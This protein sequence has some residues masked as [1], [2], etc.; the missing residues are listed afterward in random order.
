MGSY[1]PST[2][3]NAQENEQ[4]PQN[5]FLTFDITG[6]NYMN[7]EAQKQTAV[8]ANQD[9]ETELVFYELDSLDRFFSFGFGLPN[10]EDSV[11]LLG[12]LRFV[13]DESTPFEQEVFHLEFVL[14]EDRINLQAKA[15]GS[16]RYNNLEVLAKHLKNLNWAGGDLFGGSQISQFLLSFPSASFKEHQINN[17]TLTSNGF[18]FEHEIL[19]F[20]NIAYHQETN[21]IDL[22]GAFTLEMKELSCGFYSFFLVENGNFHALI[23]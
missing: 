17:Q 15:N 22:S 9:I 21:Q 4:A 12:Q 19:D 1:G 2:I 20:T 13:L 14:V 3:L 5:Y 10:T 16:Y 6:I 18:Y 7:P 8:Y 11:A 23:K